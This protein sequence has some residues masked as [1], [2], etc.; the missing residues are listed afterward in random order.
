MQ[1]FSQEASSNQQNENTQSQLNF[2]KIII[3]YKK[4]SNS[5][6]EYVKLFGK[7]KEKI[8]GGYDHVKDKYK[9]KC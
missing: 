1:Y 2:L 4:K 7:W 8:F 6:S 5:R 3:F 9:V